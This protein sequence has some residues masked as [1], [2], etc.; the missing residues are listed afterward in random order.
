MVKNEFYSKQLAKQAADKSYNRDN[1]PE[2]GSNENSF[3]VNFFI[4]KR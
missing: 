1:G 3:A 4:T 2:T